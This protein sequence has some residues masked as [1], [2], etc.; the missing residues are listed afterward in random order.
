MS[1]TIALRIDEYGSLLVYGHGLGTPRLVSRAKGLEWHAELSALD[2]QYTATGLLS[3]FEIPDDAA[4]EFVERV[5]AA[6][7]AVGVTPMRNDYSRYPHQGEI[8]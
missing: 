6:T 1:E 5:K 4:A 3:I 7:P 8:D 2:P